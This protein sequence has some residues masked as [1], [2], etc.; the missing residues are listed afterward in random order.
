MQTGLSDLDTRRLLKAL[1]S[2]LLTKGFQ[3]SE[4]PDFLINIESREY[5]MPQNSSVGV[6]LGGGGRNLGGGISVGLP[7]GQANRER[8]IIFDFIDTQKD[9]LFWQAV[10]ISSYRDNASP[11]EREKQLNK[12]VGRVMSKYPPRK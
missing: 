1:D 9:A 7:V 8:E 10:S 11:W 2:V 4:E 12:I 3:S 6:G 5:R